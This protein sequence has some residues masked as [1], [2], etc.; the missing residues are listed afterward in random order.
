[1]WM[2]FLGILVL[3]LLGSTPSFADL[4]PIDCSSNPTIAQGTN[5]QPTDDVT[6]TTGGT[7]TLTTDQDED[8]ADTYV[9]MASL[10]IYNGVTLSHSQ[11]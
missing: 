3:A 2:C 8:G 10:I 1:M 5:F 7:C 11:N 6:L 4:V 9:S